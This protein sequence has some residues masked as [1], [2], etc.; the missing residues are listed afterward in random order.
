MIT[1]SLNL[2]RV[3]YSGLS[4]VQGTSENLLSADALAPTGKRAVIHALIQSV[5]SLQVFQKLSIVHYSVTLL[6]FVRDTV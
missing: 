3:H 6:W 2:H 5:F 4:D 1:K